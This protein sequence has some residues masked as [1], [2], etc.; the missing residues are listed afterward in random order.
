MH[1]QTLTAVEPGPWGG[2]GIRL[3][4]NEKTS[5]IEFDCGDARIKE[6]LMFDSAGRFSALGDY[7]AQRPGPQRE[8]SEA[9]RVPAKFTGKLTGK[10]MQLEIILVDSGKIIGKYDLTANKNV[11]LVKCL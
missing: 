2:N 8:G 1:K 10:D 5:D 9:D 11:R 4:V 3:Q 6:R 7:H